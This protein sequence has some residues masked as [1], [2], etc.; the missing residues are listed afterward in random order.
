M[1]ERGAAGDLLGT[2]PEGPG[3]IAEIKRASP[4]RGWIRRDLDAVATAAAY[5]AGGAWAVSVLTEARSFG[6]SLRDLSDIRSAF[7]AATLLRK[8]FVLDE[9][10]LAESRAHGADLVL[11]MVSVLGDRTGEM[12]GLAFRHRLEPLVEARNP[13]EI[14]I[15]V[16]SGARMI[17]INNRDLDTLTVDLS[18][19]ERLLPLLPPGVIPVVESGI[20]KAEEVRRL[21]KAGARLFL[22]GESLAVASNPADT[23]RGY[24]GK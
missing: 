2:I 9:Y 19:G 10:M 20:S 6:G 12:A 14:A 15:A 3:V 24:M 1:E 18:T 16:R 5:L 13:E 22:I 21:H 4:S 8:D 23:I 17:G 11:L 7:P